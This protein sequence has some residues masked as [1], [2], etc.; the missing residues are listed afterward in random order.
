MALKS[1]KSKE[2]LIHGLYFGL[3][4]VL[5]LADRG[6]FSRDF[7]ASILGTLDRLYSAWIYRRENDKRQFIKR[8]K[9]AG[10]SHERF[11]TVSVVAH[12]NY[13]R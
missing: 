1:K 13:Q 12:G 9:R 11:N 5:M 7:F 6:I 2:I 10:Q 3:F 8:E 4:P